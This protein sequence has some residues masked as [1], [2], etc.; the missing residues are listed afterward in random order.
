MWKALIAVSAVLLIAGVGVIGYLGL[1]SLRSSELY[2]IEPETLGGRTKLLSSDPQAALDRLAE[3]LT[4]TGGAG[5]GTVY[6][7]AGG[8]DLLLVAT[9]TMSFATARGRLG[10]VL[11]TLDRNGLPTS[12]LRPAAPWPFEGLLRCGTTVYR[13]DPAALCAWADDGTLGVII[14]PRGTAKRIQTNIASLRAELELRGN[15]SPT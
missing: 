10:A 6:G 3:E 4:Q 1:R 8:T 2:I 7:R 13:N 14:A 5:I 11:S 15:Q 9:A 12:E